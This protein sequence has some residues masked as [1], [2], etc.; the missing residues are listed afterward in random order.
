[1]ARAAAVGSRGSRR[2]PARIF[3]VPPGTRPSGMVPPTRP[4]TACI[5]VPSPPYATTTSMPAARASD[6][7]R[8][9]SPA[10]AV[11]ST[12]TIQPPARRVSRTARTALA[13]VRAA[14]GLAMSRACVT[15]VAALPEEIEPHLAR[16]DDVRLHRDVGTGAHRLEAGLG[17]PLIV[18][19]E[20]QTS[21]QRVG[22]R[23]LPA[24]AEAG[25]HQEERLPADLPPRREAQPGERVRR[26]SG[27]DLHVI[28]RHPE[29]RHQAA[30]HFPRH[31]AGHRAL[32]H[33]V[34]VGE[35][36]LVPRQLE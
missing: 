14:A 32:D 8:R 30:L 31:D 2:F 12:S 17:P 25:V 3:P 5:A 29:I 23:G 7:K 9:A 21:P 4:A 20:L 33:R 16:G 11:A 36:R 22:H 28:E 19:A 15:S 24:L 13:S 1:M 34:L 35:R 26:V 27:T 6:A 10:L 18:E